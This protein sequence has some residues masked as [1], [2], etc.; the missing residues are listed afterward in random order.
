M[1]HQYC[2]KTVSGDQCSKLDSR[3]LIMT[4]QDWPKASSL[5]LSL[6]QL[7]V[8]SSKA[9][10]FSRASQVLASKSVLTGGTVSVQIPPDQ[11]ITE[12][13]AMEAAV[14]AA[15]QITL[16]DYAVGPSVRDPDVADYVIK[17]ETPGYKQLCTTQKMRKAGGFV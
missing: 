2:I 7:L 15:M 17:P 8:D 13:R 1:Q 12:A 16:A 3:P 6:L 9:M 14:W 10:G 11:W 4:S 5:Q